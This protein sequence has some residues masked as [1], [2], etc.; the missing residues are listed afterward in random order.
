MN[1]DPITALRDFF[2]ILDEM[3]ALDKSIEHHDGLDW[4][5]RQA[6]DALREVE[7]K[8][9]PG[10]AKSY[11]MLLGWVAESFKDDELP[12]WVHDLVAQSTVREQP[13]VLGYQPNLMPDEWKSDLVC[14]FYSFMIFRTEDECRT[15]FPQHQPVAIRVR[16]IDEPTFVTPDDIKEKE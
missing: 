10:L 2:D 4:R 14:D 6:R 3:A 1:T 9:P 16:D 12:D 15:A 11:D 13:P 5:M 7:P 8:D